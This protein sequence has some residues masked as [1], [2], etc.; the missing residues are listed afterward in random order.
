MVFDIITAMDILRNEFPSDAEL[1]LININGGINIRI[2]LYH[3]EKWHNVQ[4]NLM[5][6]E[7]FDSYINEFNFKFNSVIRKLKILIEE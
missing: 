5:F 6:Y 3:N 1:L 7:M 4:F 2:R